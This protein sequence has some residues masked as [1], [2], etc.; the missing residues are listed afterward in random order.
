MKPCWWR[1]ERQ[2]MT[3][4][5]PA[6]VAYARVAKTSGV[7]TLYTCPSLTIDSSLLHLLV[8]DR[9]HLIS[10][11]RVTYSN[12]FAKIAGIINTCVVTKQVRERG[13]D[14]PQ[15][16]DVTVNWSQFSIMATGRTD[17]ARATHSWWLHIRH[18]EI[19][20]RYMTA[21]GQHVVTR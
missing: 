5:K 19:S 12:L 8:Y 2:C 13:R 18:G 7:R 1:I 3:I 21:L 6:C 4:W 15:T 20:E 17:F 10:H 9:L 11:R 16:G 14:S